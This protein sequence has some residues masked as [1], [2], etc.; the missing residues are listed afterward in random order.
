MKEFD[1]M[2][3]PQPFSPIKEETPVK[4]SEQKSIPELEPPWGVESEPEPEINKE[5]DEGPLDEDPDPAE[6]SPVPS[7]REEPEEEVKKPKK[8]KPKKPKGPYENFVWTDLKQ[9]YKQKDRWSIQFAW[10]RGAKRRARYTEFKRHQGAV[11]GKAYGG[12]GA[13]GLD[14]GEEDVKQHE[15]PTFSW[16][17]TDTE[18]THLPIPQSDED[19]MAILKDKF[20]FDQF[21]SG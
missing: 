7:E 13:S 2:V 12:Y 1:N 3:S 8:T 9:K 10:A 14:G 21:F 4:S 11:L 5:S 15:V 16:G 20:N 18:F 17:F 6:P 19:Y